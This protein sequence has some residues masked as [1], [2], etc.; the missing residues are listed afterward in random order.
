MRIVV[1]GLSITSSWGNGHATLWRALV[2][3][4]AERGHSV[5]FFE[6]Q[7]PWYAAHRDLA[8]P[9]G[10]AVVLY[11]DWPEAAARRTMRSGLAPGPARPEA[12]PP[13]SGLRRHRC[14]C[15]QH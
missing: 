10:A 4:L 8:S 14:P 5:T 9:P 2:R 3:A 6:R 11:D 13:H 7:A 1:F 12:D 15:G